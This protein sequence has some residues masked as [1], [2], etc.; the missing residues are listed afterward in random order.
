MVKWTIN[1][2]ALRLRMNRAYK[3]REDTIQN[4][5]EKEDNSQRIASDN[6]RSIMK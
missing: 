3:K 4:F 5:A 6:M 1:F 2:D